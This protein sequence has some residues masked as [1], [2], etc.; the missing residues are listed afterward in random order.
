MTH[1]ESTFNDYFTCFQFKF[2]TK[3]A[4]L[5]SIEGMQHANNHHVLTSLKFNF[6]LQISRTKKFFCSS[7][8]HF[9]YDDLLTFVR[10]LWNV[11]ALDWKSG[12]FASLTVADEF[13][14]P[15][16]IT[17]SSKL[18]DY[19]YHWLA[20]FILTVI[21]FSK[22]SH[23]NCRQHKNYKDYLFRPFS[24]FKMIFFSYFL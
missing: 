13:E 23:K 24:L 19:F 10:F 18:F 17:S 12:L 2:S 3:Y 7:F 16:P 11:S 1:D 14:N 21:N 8:I 9:N 6:K 20:L 22:Y 5:N 4:K 15:Q